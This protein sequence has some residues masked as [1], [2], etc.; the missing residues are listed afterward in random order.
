MTQHA[1]YVTVADNGHVWYCTDEEAAGMMRLHYGLSWDEA[2]VEIPDSAEQEHPGTW[3]DKTHESV[4][5]Q[6]YQTRAEELHQ[7]GG[8]PERRA[9]AVALREQGKTYEAIAERLDLSGRGSAYEHVSE[10]K[11]QRERAQWLLKNGP[12]DAL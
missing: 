9:E 6:S 12:S 8:V 7:E 3:V 4:G 1:H 11:A 2:A 5:R 10:Y